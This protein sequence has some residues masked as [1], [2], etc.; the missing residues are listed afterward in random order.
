MLVAVPWFGVVLGLS[1]AAGLVV[2]T[3]NKLSRPHGFN[4]CCRTCCTLS[5]GLVCWLVRACSKNTLQIRVCDSMAWSHA[6]RAAA[7]MVRQRGSLLP[8]LQMAAAEEESIGVE[9]STHSVCKTITMVESSSMAV[10][11]RILL[12]LALHYP[13]GLSGAMT[14]SVV[15]GCAV[16]VVSVVTSPNGSFSGSSFMQKF[17]KLIIVYWLS[18]MVNSG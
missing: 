9:W 18:A 10:M 7:V 16:L 17:T 13:C 5:R 15:F 14:V 4:G 3:R 8:L 12:F 2:F 6:S 11:R 1:L